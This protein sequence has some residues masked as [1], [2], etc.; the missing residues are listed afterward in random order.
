MLQ[1][2]DKCPCVCYHYDNGKLQQLSRLSFLIRLIIPLKAI[3][4]YF[5][6]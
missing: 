5:V 3:I 1:T 2:V 6:Y 4:A